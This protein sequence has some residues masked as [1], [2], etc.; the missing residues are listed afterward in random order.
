MKRILSRTIMLLV[1]IFGLAVPAQAQTYNVVDAGNAW[2][3]DVI[4][5]YTENGT[6]NGK[7]CYQGPNG[8]WLYHGQWFSDD[9][10]FLGKPKGDTE[11]NNSGVHFYFQ[12]SASTPPLNTNYYNT[13]S[14]AGSVR[15]TTSGGSP[16]P[17]PS[18]VMIIQT[19]ASSI[20]IIWD[21]ISS[22]TGYKL[23]LSTVSNFSSFIAGYNP[24]VITIPENTPI[25]SRPRSHLMTGLSPGTTYHFR[26]RAYNGFGD[27]PNSS[28]LSTTTIPGTPT[29]QPATDVTDNGFRA[30]WTA[31]SGASGYWLYVSTS[32]SFSSDVVNLYTSNNYYQVTGL[33]PN[34]TYYYRVKATNLNGESG[35][36]G[37]TQVTTAPAKPVVQDAT[38]IGASQFTVNWQSSAGATGYYLDVAT[39]SSFNNL[40]TGYAGINVGNVTSYQVNQGINPYTTYYV[41]V[42]AYNANGTSSDSNTVSVLTLPVLAAVTTSSVTEIGVNSALAGGA[43]TS[44]GVPAASQHG[45]CWNTSGSPTIGDFKTEKGPAA[46][47]G[48]YS[49]YLTGLLPDTRYYVRAY[50]TNEGGTSYGEQLPFDTLVPNT[51]P[52]ITDTAPAL[53]STDEDTA[54]API[55]IA[56]FLVSSD[57]DPD[58]LTGIAI[59][60]LEGNGTWQYSLE[61]ITWQAVGAVSST[62]AL[63]LRSSDYIRYTP[64]GVRGET[65]RVSFRAWDQTSGTYGTSADVTTN[66]GTTAFSA[67]TATASLVVT[68]INDAPTLVSNT[69]LTVDE[70][71][72]YTLTGSELSCLD[73]DNSPSEL[74]YNVVI[75]PEHGVLQL[76][77]N[78]LPGGAFTQDDLN[79]GR[80]TYAHDGSE[81]TSDSF[82]FTVS[83]G[84]GGQIGNTVFLITINPVNDPPG[85]IV[86]SGL[87]MAG[88]A[89]A[90]ID[91]TR[92]VATDPDNE[93]ETLL[94]TITAAPTAGTLENGGLPLI[95]GSSFT[96]AHINSGL[97][98]YTHGGGE[99]VADSF[100]FTVSDGVGGSTGGTFA[101]SIEPAVLNSA[102]SSMAV[103]PGT[104]AADGTATATI[105]VVAR[106]IN[107]NPLPGHTI[108]LDQGRGGSVITPVSSVTNDQGEA[109][110][111]VKSLRAETVIYTAR[112]VTD[113]TDIRTIVQ[114]ASVTF[115]PV[116]TINPTLGTLVEGHSMSYQLALVSRPVEEVVINVLAGGQLA[117][118][119]GSLTFTGANYNIPQLVNVTAVDN[120]I[121]DGTRTETVSHSVYSADAAYNGLSI[122]G[123]VITIIDN[124]AP[125][126]SVIQSGGHTRVTE[127]AGP[128]SYSLV[129]NTE[130]K[131]SVE[132]SISGDSQLIVDPDNLI[133]TPVN[134]SIPQ[135]VN[136]WA[137][138]DDLLEWDHAGTVTHAVYS[139]DPHYSNYL[140][141]D[142]TV[143]ITDNDASANA[144]LAGLS[145]SSGELT[146]AFKADLTGYTANVAY[147]VSSVNVTATPEDDTAAIFINGQ[148]INV[149]GQPGTIDLNVGSNTIT[150]LVTAQDNSTTKEYVITMHRASSSSSRNRNSSRQ[151]EVGASFQVD[152]QAGGSLGYDKVTVDI[153]AGSLPGDDTVSI[154][155]LNPAE[156]AEVSPAGLQIKLAGSIYEITTSGERHFGDNNITI[157]IIFDQ[158]QIAAGEVPVIHYYDE[159][160]ARWVP[161]VTETFQEDGVWYAVTR[162]NHLTKFAVLSV[163]GSPRGQ[164]EVI[165]YIGRTS[166]TVNGATY[167]L[168]AAPFV[169]PKAN[170]TLVPLRFLAEALGAD[171]GWDG[172]AQRVIIKDNGQVIILT[173]GSSTALVDGQVRAIDCAVLTRPPGRTFIPLR[174]VSETLGARVD[175]NAENREIIITRPC[176]D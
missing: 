83:D 9:Y 126:I 142:L 1:L 45:F 122:P 4:G 163:A 81:T 96:Q 90:V 176:N 52:T 129:L 75:G 86:N 164:L 19:T 98:T 84:A 17:A 112:D 16:P 55:L 169:D 174:F 143:Q 146:P 131:G 11:L 67:N 110:F 124:D 13:S 175:Y 156:V 20:N 119:Q 54:T 53:G 64:D 27:S 170:R 6:V 91:N 34:T 51:A 78:P 123:V 127:G 57:P 66:G 63:L 22:A 159:I 48:I 121:A 107:D 144:R 73:P 166:A 172:V 106:N 153:P 141:P 69:G 105:T 56:S 154:R 150:V 173:L 118:D 92:L 138:D 93:D 14:S 72:T 87:S 15:V 35:L 32:S 102:A 120:N 130:P 37:H 5:V 134:W 89:V 60:G 155:R 140:I 94:F 100:T 157:S 125:G 114:T 160:L 136:V 23:E 147:G 85:I 76:S 77:G 62:G 74:T 103:Q 158:A 148:Q 167:T 135:V 117:V 80:V 162:V 21:D 31:Q 111:T 26:M 88:G 116:I 33:S 99:S 113:D 168:D 137:V 40:V 133:F 165:L 2:P 128:D 46:A 71:N 12:S 161:L 151:G 171:V 36:S 79:S 59:Y 3:Q 82:T 149:P 68:D 41:R 47:T 61:G 43:I 30:N 109:V 39:N 58:A 115:N 152:A 29:I 108:T 8:Y 49:S 44:L 95:A 42:R 18:G 50:A 101:I 24:Y 28:T 10:W 104:L 65:A 97:L 7:P 25:G 132:V 38:G 70:G 139:T 145:I